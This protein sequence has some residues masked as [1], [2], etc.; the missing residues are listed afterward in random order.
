MVTKPDPNN[1][2][3]VPDDI[4]EEPK[5]TTTAELPIDY[6]KHHILI[7]NGKVKRIS[8]SSA[9]LLDMLCKE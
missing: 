3:T 8:H 1:T 7:V 9:Y 4:V 2:F 6:E 5:V